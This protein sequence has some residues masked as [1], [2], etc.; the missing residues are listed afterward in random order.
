MLLPLLTS[1]KYYRFPTISILLVVANVAVFLMTKHDILGNAR[2]WGFIPDHSTGW[3]LPFSAQGDRI[4]T[5]ISH[6]FLHGGWMHLV[7]NMW[8]LWVF[9]SALEVKLG[10]LR[11]AL[12]Y[13]LCA[14]G[15]VIVHG[16]LV[17]GPPR[18]AIGA[19]GAISGVLGCYLAMEPRSRVLSVFF[20]VII[21]FFT[22]IPT[23]FYVL[24]WLIIQLDGIQSHVL[25]SPHCRNI[26]WWAH[27]GGF[28]T[29]VIA[30]GVFLA[31]RRKNKENP[32][33]PDILGPPMRRD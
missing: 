12:A 15:A 11:F 22:E 1:T 25:G 17:S 8:M 32:Q 2:Q 16:A 33:R 6:A 30:A 13:I 3:V 7:G 19:S 21:F 28:W 10:H 4:E 27:I 24:I 9:G 18:P 26:A 31:A 20:L 5:L 23:A 14:V 29:G